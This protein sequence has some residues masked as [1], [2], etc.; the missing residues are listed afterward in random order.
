MTGPGSVPMPM[1]DGVTHRDVEAGGVRFH[2]AEAGSAN[3]GAPPVLLLHGWPQH[4]WAWRKVIPLLAS[5]RRVIAPDL[6]GFGWSDAPP[7]RYEMATFATDT[8]AILD[9]LGVGEVDL[10]AHDWGAYAGFLLALDHPDR[11]RHYVA[12]NMYPPWPDPPSVRGLVGIWRLWYQAALA[13]PGLGRALVRRTDFPR[14]IIT[15]AAAHDDAWT[16]EDLE[17]FT[18]PLRE[19]ARADAS[20]HLYRSFLTR[21]LRPYLAGRYRDRRLSVPTVLL[22]G[23]RDLAIDQNRLGE[24]EKYADDMRVELFDDSGH[25]VAEELPEVVAD[26]ARTGPAR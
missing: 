18:A 17:S 4:W 8:L 6:R 9:E 3:G 19:P 7:G 10:V 13:S 15:T 1:L 11:I 22:V 23:T 16:E 12:I 25:F 26:R 21:E 14:R 5:E 20:V 2:V 24:W